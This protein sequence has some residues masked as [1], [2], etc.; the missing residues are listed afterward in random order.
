ML[1]DAAARAA[2]LA[3]VDARRDE[4][5]ELLQELIRIPSVNHA[6]HGDELAC[7]RF[8]EHT[9]RDMGLEVDV[10]TPDIIPGI[11]QH[12]GWCPDR[13]YTDRPNVVGARHGAGR[14]RSVLLL[15]HADVVPEGPHELW[16]HGPFNPVVENGE[17]IGRGSNDD[18]GG[19]AALLMAL[20]CVEA[21]GYRAAGDVILASVVDEES[22]G[23]N[24]T[25]AVLL[26]E[27]LADAAVYC[28]GIDLNLHTAN[29]GGAHCSITLQ[30]RPEIPVDTV[31]QITQILD[32][33]YQDMLRFGQERIGVLRSDPRYAPTCWPELA[34]RVPFLQ[35]GAADFSNPGGAHMH[36]AFYF[37]PGEE[38][39]AVQAQVEDRVRAL[40]AR[41]DNLLL[42]PR[43]EW[44]GRVMPPSA[45]ADDDPFVETVAAA[46]QSAT[47][48]A[49]LRHGMPMSDLFQFNL[50]SPRPMPT[51]AMGPG[52]WAVPGGAHQPNE[53]VLIDEH[54]IP[55]VKVLALLIVDW[56]G[57]VQ[58]E[59]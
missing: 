39:A 22:G 55:F 20:R 26:R 33:C 53:S 28:D 56:C 12:P 6:T 1:T 51:V 58:A 50:Y 48:T 46:Y 4:I 25:L 9:M 7:Q 19:L 24:G 10:F 35:A 54:L 37:L 11:T 41:F 17:L 23:A 18:K 42:E 47:G 16:R 31:E 36:V 32:A 38:P 44:R 30:L 52:R 15:A 43:I 40:L 59:L 8:V 14:G 2:V 21:A 13:D 29:L 57:V 49:A 34:V 5:V 3:A 27:H 45:V